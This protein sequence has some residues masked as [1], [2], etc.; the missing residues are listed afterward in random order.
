MDLLGYFASETLLNLAH[1]WV[2][3]KNADIS[4][5]DTV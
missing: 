5:A 1:L 4:V 3:E 2:D